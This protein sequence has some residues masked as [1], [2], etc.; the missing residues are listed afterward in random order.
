[1]LKR[2]LGSHGPEVSALALG[3][4]GMSEFYGKRDDA[5]SIATIDRALDLGVTFLDTA[6]MYGSGT[7]EELI[8]RAIAGKRDRVFLATKFGIVRDA[9][10]PKQRGYNGRPEYVR[11]ACDASLKRLGTDHIDLYY[12]HRV[13]PL[14]PIEETVGA[15]ADLIQAGKVRYIGLSEC[16]V[17]TLERAIKETPVTAVQ[18]E[19]S[20]FTRDAEDGVLDVC[21]RNG[22]GFV[23]YSPLGRGF[24]TGAITSQQQFE[25]GDYRHV[26]PRFVGDNFE[27]NLKLVATVKDLAARKGTAPG[28][29]ALAWLLTRDTHLVPLFGTKRRTYLDENVRAVDVVLSPA[30][31]AEIGAAFPR[32]IASGAR[33]P[34]SAIG[35]VNR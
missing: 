10:D 19:Y 15:M 23:A 14:T 12:Q 26:S 1:M 30:E 35:S 16:S 6:D 27:K 20:L 4:M 34:D 18:W 22:I 3:C 29:I 32:G 8:A 31:L 33:Y 13:D 9:T 25:P 5:E 2:R 11:Q 24:L 17:A 21:R 7:N 28:N